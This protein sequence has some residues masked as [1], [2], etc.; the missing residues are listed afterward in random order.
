[1]FERLGRFVVRHARW[2]LVGSAIALVVGA[3]LGVTA[4]T[5]LQDGGQEDPGA[6]STRAAVLLEEKFGGQTDYLFLVPAEGPTGPELTA[7]LQADRR[8]TNVASYWSTN[9]PAMKSKDGSQAIVVASD[10]DPD[11][12]PKPIIADYRSD[13][14]RVG[15]PAATFEAVSDQI[16][17]DLALAESI[18]IPL[19]LVL[20]VLAF[21][22]VVAALLTLVIGGISIMGTF[23]ELSVLGSFTD[24]SVYAVNMTTA[25]GL[26]L[27][28]DYGLLLIA[29]HRERRESGDSTD[30]AVV[31]AVSTAGRT[32][33]FS[34]ATVAVA[35]AALVIFPPYFLRSFAY[36]GIGVVLISA[37]AALIALPALLAVLGPR[38][39]AWRIPGVR[40]IHGEATQLWAR[41]ARF[42]MR[43]PVLV[44]VPVVAILL[45]AAAPLLGVKF[46]TPD[47]RVLPTSVQARQVGDAMRNNFAGADVNALTVVTTTGADVGEYASRLSLLPNVAQVDSSAGTFEKGT[48]LA[49]SPADARFGRGDAQQLSVVTNL[50]PASD[51]ART[52]VDDVRA[53]APPAGAEALVGGEMAVLR[54]S[55][56]SIGAHLPV[57]VGWIVATTV[58][59]LFLFTGSI[60]QPLRALVLNA[61]SLGATLGVMVLIFQEGYLSGLL[62]FTPAPLDVSMLLLLF[63]VTFG[64]SMDY[65]VF[66]VSRIK[67]LHD[68][69]LDTEEAVV[70]GL[71]RTGRLVTTAA[72]LISISFFA[73]VTSDVRFIQFFGLGTGLAIIIDA[74]LVRGVLVP[75]A[76]RWLGKAAW[77]APTP[78][79][80]VHRKVAL[81]DA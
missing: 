27:A 68:R 69:G 3:V 22:N 8:L 55:L 52:L 16:G 15:G 1:M 50:D 80:A 60:M 32:I 36:A 29:R 40:G 57:A 67:E 37:L 62:G 39:D 26:G 64:L 46:G 18:V 63:C 77:Y 45:L 21:G 38:V 41:I 61:L 54:D 12:D 79:R 24:V 7:K 48:R 11:Q 78:L 71:A 73:F 19:T 47:D 4:F 59:L 49:L 25:L 53:V 2:V 65:E 66:V 34:A 44:G 5:K 6:E 72:G 13:Q 75:V 81:V 9:S 70:Q 56:A 76:M 17:A 23:A 58:V 42:A 74:T 10:A 35:L 31:F 43:K 33:A 30:A 51:A 28:M 20:L 14:V